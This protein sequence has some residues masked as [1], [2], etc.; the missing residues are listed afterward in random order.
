MIDVKIGLA[1]RYFGQ[2]GEASRNAAG[3]RLHKTNSV[4]GSRSAQTISG[5]PARMGLTFCGRAIALA[6]G[7]AIFVFDSKERNQEN[8]FVCKRVHV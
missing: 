8:D 2:F 3:T 1:A 5:E 4:R 7:T 6:F